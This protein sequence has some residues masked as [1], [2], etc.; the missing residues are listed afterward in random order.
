MVILNAEKLR[1]TVHMAHITTA[2]SFLLT[3]E[4]FKNVFK[5]C[6]EIKKL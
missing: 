5:S 2:L 3:V 6:E 4:R 1:L